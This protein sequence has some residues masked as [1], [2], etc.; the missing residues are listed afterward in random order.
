M[1]VKFSKKRKSLHD[2]V[3]QLKRRLVQQF[4]SKEMDFRKTFGDNIYDGKLCT[5]FEKQVTIEKFQ[6]TEG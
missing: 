2:I 5:E 3:M 6:K 4:E 1:G